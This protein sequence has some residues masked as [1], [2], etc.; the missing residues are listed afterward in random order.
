M[1]RL[2]INGKSYPVD[3]PPDTPLLWVLRDE[4]GL[5]GTKFGCGMALCGAC[6]VH[7]DG[8]PGRA[9]V[10][11]VSAL[12]GKRSSPSR[13]SARTVG[14]RGAG[15]LGRRGRA[16]VRLLPG[17]PD[18]VGD[19][20]AQEASPSRPTP[21]S[22]TRWRATSAAA[23]PTRRIRSGHQAGRRTA[24]SDG[25]SA[26]LTSIRL[27]H[28]ADDATLVIV[29]VSRRRFVKGAAARAVSCSRPV[30]A[31]GARRRPA[32]VRRRRHAARLGRQSDGLRRGSARTAPSPSSA[33]AP[34][35][36]R[37][38]APACR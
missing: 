32:E 21:T 1:T 11:P 15:G 13:A 23:A 8:E 3:V 4:L 26:P 35:W 38:C 9:C 5:T 14:K 28:I 19:G 33:T 31:G 29:N 12:A 10:T 16:A 27:S 34:R 6:T 20:A 25:M 17:G 22:T 37:A 2:E 30:R 24:G 7:V 18:H 36:A